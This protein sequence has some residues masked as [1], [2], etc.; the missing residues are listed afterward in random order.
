MTFEAKQSFDQGS[1]SVGTRFPFHCLRET[2]AYVC[3]WDG[4]LVRVPENLVSNNPSPFF[5]VVSKDPLFVTKIS[6]DPFVSISKA[7][8]VASNLDVPINF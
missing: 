2:G 6:E 3:N 4:N 8:S 7:R 1:N 5:N